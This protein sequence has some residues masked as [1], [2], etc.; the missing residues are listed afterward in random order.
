MQKQPINE[1]ARLAMSLIDSLGREGAIHV[2]RANGWDGVL[3]H[4]L[5]PD[6]E[7]SCD[8]FDG[9]RYRN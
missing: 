2:C 7:R 6:R 3:D 1:Q 5:G 9:P 8:P 4:L